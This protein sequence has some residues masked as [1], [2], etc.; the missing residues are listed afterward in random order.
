MS[1]QHDLD[2]VVASCSELSHHQQ[3]DHPI[4]ANTPS[5]LPVLSVPNVCPRDQPP[6]TTHTQDDKQFAHNMIHNQGTQPPSRSVFPQAEV[7]SIYPASGENTSHQT[8]HLSMD[9][10][11]SID[12]MLDSAI[13]GIKDNGVDQSSGLN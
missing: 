8:R 5:H 7:V 1:Q 12:D 6:S 10:T 4:T 11:S 2:S 13:T 3:P 9:S